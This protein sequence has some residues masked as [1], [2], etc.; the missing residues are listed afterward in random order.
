M[1]LPIDIGTNLIITG[2]FTV[3]SIIR[4]YIWRRFFNAGAKRIVRA[5]IKSL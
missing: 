3:V 4:S 5:W 2:I 1:H